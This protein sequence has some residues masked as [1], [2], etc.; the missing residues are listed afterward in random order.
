MSRFKR[1]TDAEAR[2]LTR[3]ELLDRIEAEQAYWFRKKTRTAED[4]AAFREFTRIM[5]AYLSPASIAEAM[6]DTIDYIEGRSP[7][8]YWDTRPGEE[9]PKL[10]PMDANQHAALDYARRVFGIGERRGEEN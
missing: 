4:D 9:T 6:Q 10:P 5:Y 2:T 3:C 1:L 7:G 8:S